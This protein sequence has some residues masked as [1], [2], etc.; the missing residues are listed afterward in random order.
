MR[1]EPVQLD[2]GDIRIAATVGITRQIQNIAAGRR[3]R[4]KAAPEFGWNIHV[5]GAMAELAVAKYLKRF[6]NGN[7]GD[8]KAADVGPL[9]VRSTWHPDGALTIYPKDPD[10][11]VFV[12]VTGSNG[13]YLLRGHLLGKIAKQDKFYNREASNNRR[14]TNAWYVPQ[15]ELYPIS[16]LLEF[17]PGIDLSGP[18]FYGIDPGV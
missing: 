5:E 10:D 18:E 8:L 15:D 4:Y 16:T 3:D 7:L 13:E 1:Y 2:L 17:A 12:L 11:R 6:W 9:E 14:G